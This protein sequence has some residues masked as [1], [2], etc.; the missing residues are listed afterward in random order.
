LEF[1]GLC[2]SC[3]KKQPD[4]SRPYSTS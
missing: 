4:G 1:Y 3:A 2:K